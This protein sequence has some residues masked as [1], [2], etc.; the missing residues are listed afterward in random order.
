MSS[1]LMKRL[2]YLVRQDWLVT[3]PAKGSKLASSNKMLAVDCEMVLCEDG[4]D[5]LVRVC[6]VDSDLQ[7]KLD[8]KVKPDKPITDYRT[9]I[10]GIKSGDLDDVTFS[11]RN[12]Q[13]RMKKLLSKGTTILVGHGLYNDLLALKIDHARVVDTSFIF[14]TSDGR[15]PSLR[16]LCK[17][18]LGYELRE[19]GAPHN[20]LD[21]ARTAMKIVLAKMNGVD[22]VIQRTAKHVSEDEQAWLLLHKIPSVVPTEEL[23]RIFPMNFTIQLK[24]VKRAEG[25][26]Y[27]VLAIFKTLSEA[28]EAFEKVDGVIDKDDAG[29]V[30]KLTTLAS[31]EGKT[32][33]L[34]VRKM[35]PEVSSEDSQLKRPLETE[36]HGSRKKQKT[37]QCDSHREEI[38]RLKQELKAKDEA[39]LTEIEK[40]KKEMGAKDLQ[41]DTYDKIIAELKQ[42][43]KEKKER[44][45]R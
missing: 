13:R 18:I 17:T 15:P 42:K 43:L 34:F 29:R 19:E 4:T 28:D 6:V 20:C 38:E 10:T 11:L 44:S 3:K 12:V 24:P 45:K 37:G 31:N 9:E 1:L 41:I 23:R 7:V 8:E 21:D 40:L 39:H 27:T 16:D 14:K 33:T 35:S 2:P 30:Q 26:H 5:G 25:R 32:C 36:D 22:K